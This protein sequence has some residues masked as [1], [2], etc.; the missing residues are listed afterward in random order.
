MQG[1]K[2]E[3]YLSFIQLYVLVYIYYMHR[4]SSEIQE[5]LKYTTPVLCLAGY[6]LGIFILS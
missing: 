4:K 6:G 5:V 1:L 2:S 3:M